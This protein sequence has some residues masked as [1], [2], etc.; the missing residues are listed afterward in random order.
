MLSG[1]ILFKNLPP[2]L[3][4]L[5]FFG[6]KQ[7]KFLVF[8][9]WLSLYM[10][11]IPAFKVTYIKSVGFTVLYIGESSCISFCKTTLSKVWPPFD[12]GT[13]LPSTTTQNGLYSC[14]WPFI[15][16]TLP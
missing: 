7:P 6:N 5:G 9:I 8:K 4:E 1:K 16:T 13:T 14:S 15:F 2:V 12:N 10:L 3:L 11:D